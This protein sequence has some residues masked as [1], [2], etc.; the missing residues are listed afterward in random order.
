MIHSEM[1]WGA[2]ISPPAL[3]P[4]VVTSIV[5]GRVVT[6]AARHVGSHV[7]EHFAK[8][9]IVCG[10]PKGNGVKRMTSAV[11]DEV[12]NDCATTMSAGVLGEVVTAG[13]LFAA[14]VALK[15]LLLCVE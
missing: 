5:L 14:F 9:M 10:G 11:V 7:E 8:R 13:E 4:A 2:S 12:H 6:R 1:L 3:F 15:R